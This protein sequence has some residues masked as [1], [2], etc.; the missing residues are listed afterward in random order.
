[1][2][3]WPSFVIETMQVLS[4]PYW[5]D[6]GEE[7]VVAF[8]HHWNGLEPESLERAA[9][10]A[11][12]DELV[13]AT[14]LLAKSGD[15]VAANELLRLQRHPKQR[16][17]RWWSALLLAELGDG[18][19]REALETMLTEG[20]PSQEAF[21]DPQ[22]Q[23]QETL[24]WILQRADAA[25]RLGVVGG[26]ASLVLLRQALER[27]LALET[28]IPAE[29]DS[30]IVQRL[31]RYQSAL[32]T[33]LGQLGGL[34]SLTG[35]HPVEPAVWIA[36]HQ[37]PDPG[38]DNAQPRSQLRPGWHLMML[39]ID[40]LMGHLRRQFDPKLVY[41][42]GGFSFAGV[43][44]LREKLTVELRQI[45]AWDADTTKYAL[46]KYEIHQLSDLSFL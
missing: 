32:A 7:S 36:H 10:E 35:L 5:E 27:A 22:V 31:H 17:V 8:E 13:L 43:P 44:E 16:D 11:S 37:P 18:R 30:F 26:P 4:L 33:A 3:A 40:L 1:M 9:R 28:V 2:R 6:G 23:Q 34:G 15:P 20:L 14:V 42:R 41:S 29:A 45:F 38:D 25:H 39:S 46:E 21:T 24:S 12:G 19:A